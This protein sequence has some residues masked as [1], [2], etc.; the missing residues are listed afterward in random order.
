MA[1]LQLARVRGQDGPH[2]I[3]VIKQVLP[4][5][6]T[7]PEFLDMFH[8]EARIAARLDHPNIARVTD[9][10]ELD[11]SPFLA[12][13]YVPGADLRE[14]LRRSAERPPLPMNYGVAVVLAVAAGLHHAHEQRAHDG[15]P[16]G[17]VHRD[18]SPSNVLV[19][20]D[21]IVKV[22]DFGIAR[23][24]AHTR[25]TQAGILKGKVG[26]M[27][28][29]QCRSETVD[30]RSDVFGLGILLYEATTGV[31][32]FYGDNE[33]AVMN[34]IV[35]GEY[36]PPGD[37]RPGYPDELA[38]I[39]R[40]AL[41][42][43]PKDRYLTAAAMAEDL[44]VFAKSHGL[45][46][47]PAVLSG[48]V[49]SVCGPQTPLDAEADTSL[50]SPSRLR[51]WLEETTARHRRRRGLSITAAVVVALGL[52][53]GGTVL[54]RKL[55]EP[56]ERDK[57]KPE[58]VFVPAADPPAPIGAG[59]GTTASPDPVP[60]GGTAGEATD[61]DRG[62]PTPP[63]S[64]G[65]AKQPP[66]SRRVRRKRS[67]RKVDKPNDARPVDLEALFPPEAASEPE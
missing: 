33:Y 60:S 29:E 58:P 4:H 17:I 65:R 61:S 11:G 22:V 14:L 64:A 32:L 16:L 7:D 57:P 24:A 34:A 67:N 28:P 51:R 40:R 55:A 18:V 35:R 27:S 48:W 1:E 47:D 6:A 26:Y 63:A 10:G 23:A 39:V 25:R 19:S 30:R 9:F 3:V 66:R 45:N 62:Q 37:V 2:G 44:A 52:T 21:G 12:M 50:A 49:R 38:R 8:N 53:A 43:D 15:G 42:V 36:D 56:A 5:L 54:G 31:R 13:E 46:T 20:Y 59:P 41:E